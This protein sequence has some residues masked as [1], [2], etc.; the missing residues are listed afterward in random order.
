[1]A[2][3]FCDWAFQLTATCTLAPA[4]MVTVSLPLATPVAGRQRPL[5]LTGAS[6]TKRTPRRRKSIVESPVVV[7]LPPRSP[8]PLATPE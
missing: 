6:P 1:M 5:P 7:K 4:G 2:R 8:G 3:A